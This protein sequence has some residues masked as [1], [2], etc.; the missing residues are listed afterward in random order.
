MF[1]QLQRSG[2]H[3]PGREDGLRG[4]YKTDAHRASRRGV[5]EKQGLPRKLVTAAAP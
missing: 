5:H 1:P 3:S 2:G 4:C